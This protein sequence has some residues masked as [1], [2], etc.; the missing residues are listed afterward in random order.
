MLP[1]RRLAGVPPI[2]KVLICGVFKEDAF[3]K[4]GVVETVVDSR[5]PEIRVSVGF[6]I[7]EPEPAP[8]EINCNKLI[9]GN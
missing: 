1:S 9:L 8:N 6:A 4:F 5:Q 3:L 2:V 7:P